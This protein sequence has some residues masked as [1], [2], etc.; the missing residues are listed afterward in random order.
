MLKE[1]LNKHFHGRH[2]RQQVLFSLGWISSDR[3]L[4]LL[5][6]VTV[7]VWVARY[8]GPEAFG[9]LSFALAFTGLF[10]PFATLGLETVGVKQFVETPQDEAKIQGTIFGL[11]LIA[12]ILATLAS[13]AIHYA[14]RSAP[15]IVDHMVIL[16]AIT[17]IFQSL[18]GI[19]YWFY[20]RLEGKYPVISKYPGYIISNLY[21]VV[22][23][24]TL[25]APLPF[26]IA[27]SLEQFLSA[28]GNVAVYM[29]R[30]FSPKR[31]QFSMELAR[32]MLPQCAPLIFASFAIAVYPR[33]SQVVLGYNA[34]PK[35]LGEF[36]VAM[37]LYDLVAFLPSTISL[38]I[39]PILVESR[40]ESQ[41][42]LNEKTQQ[43]Y[44]LMAFSGYVVSAV[45]IL[46]GGPV[47]HLMFGSQYEGA[48]LPL[49]AIF[50]GYVFVNLGMAQSSYFNSQGLTHYH[51][52]TAGVGS[53]V[54]LVLA[55]YLSPRYGALGAAISTALAQAIALIAL[56]LFAPGARTSGRMLLRS[57]VWPKFW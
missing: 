24:L 56:G 15:G 43:F 42:R 20:A 23:I 1:F 26:S 27:N 10:Y 31:W 46:F 52:I 48:E 54:N 51:A 49:Q 45:V 32:K 5:F 34:S 16:A 13:I 9:S 21:R 36:A 39:F 44:N 17:L 35:E 3:A 18:D 25:Q 53:I 6:S 8:L 28:V 19:D 14:L 4:R 29:W 11:K 50:A 37:R 57:L 12:G 30:G 55:F 38:V 41:A 2:R 22:L 33:M 40:K 7:G 47:V